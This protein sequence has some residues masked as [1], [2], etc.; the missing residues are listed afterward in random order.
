M[1]IGEQFVPE[2]ALATALVRLYVCRVMICFFCSYWIRGINYATQI[3]YYKRSVSNKIETRCV[4]IVKIQDTHASCWWLEAFLS[5]ARGV[6]CTW[7]PG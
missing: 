4:M 1:S 2:E 7:Y 3:P 6:E 5:S